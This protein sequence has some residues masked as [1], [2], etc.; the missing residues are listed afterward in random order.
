ML[1]AF[2]AAYLRGLV[3]LLV[4]PLLVEDC[5]EIS[6]QADLDLLIARWLIPIELPKMRQ[7][8]QLLLE[9]ARAGNCRRW[10]LDVRHCLNTPQV[11]A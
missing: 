1:F 3:F 5:L 10:L 9:A 4:S 8:H 11:G 2:R 6:C 7:G